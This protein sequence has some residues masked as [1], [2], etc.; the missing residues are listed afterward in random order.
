VDQRQ[1]GSHL[2]ALVRSELSAERA[3]DEAAAQ[4][5]HERGRSLPEAI[6]A[7]TAG[8]AKLTAHLAGVS[9]TGTAVHIAGD[10]LTLRTEDATEIDIQLT[11]EAVFRV[12]TGQHESG[13]LASAHGP[14]SFVARMRQLEM[15]ERPISLMT[16]AGGR[17]V[18]GSIRV[19]GSGHLV[20]DDEASTWL[21]PIQEI[22]AVIT[23]PT[24]GLS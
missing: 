6:G 20:V 23:E 14:Q 16:A 9:Y 5:Y 8:H 13:P 11:S 4:K 15:E 10:L 7:F 12:A 24:D 1:L 17:R 2:R 3:A 21:V 19:V 22:V 18:A